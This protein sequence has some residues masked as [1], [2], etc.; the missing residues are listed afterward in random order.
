M[1]L[2]VILINNQKFYLYNKILLF[3]NQI[4][5]CYLIYNKST[6]IKIK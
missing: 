6:Y 2:L 1:E 5:I 3:L 4:I